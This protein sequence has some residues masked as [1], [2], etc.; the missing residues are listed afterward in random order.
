MALHGKD[1][2]FYVGSTLVK[3]FDSFT[4]TRGIGLADVTS[5]GDAWD[6]FIAGVKNWSCAVR[7]TLDRTD[8]QQ[9][10][11]LDQLEDGTLT[12]TVCRMSM[13]RS[14][15]YW[16]GSV[17]VEGVTVDHSVKDKVGVSFNLRGHDEP[18]WEGS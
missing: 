10:A 5:Y 1:G 8:A 7:G 12:T 15:Q 18:T 4:F 13:D 17:W 9:A 3:F 16:A 14:T 2:G 6:K 11:L